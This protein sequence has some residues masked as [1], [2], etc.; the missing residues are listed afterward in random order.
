MCWAT[1]QSKK[2]ERRTRL[3]D[4]KGQWH[5]GRTDH[6]FVAPSL[7]THAL[8]WGSSY[9]LPSFAPTSSPAHPGD[10]FVIQEHH[11]TA[12][13][14]DLRLE[15]DGVLASWAVYLPPRVRRRAGGGAFL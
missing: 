4:L 14:W 2:L 9:G 13:H 10:R 1:A 15:R 11:A 7:A 6:C 5:C 8:V 12:L 3:A